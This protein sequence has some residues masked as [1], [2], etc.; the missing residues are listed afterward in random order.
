MDKHVLG[1]IGFGIAYVICCVVLI[2]IERKEP[3][4]QDE[5]LAFYTAMC[6]IMSPLC[7]AFTFVMWFYGKV[8]DIRRLRRMK[9]RE[10]ENGGMGIKPYRYGEVFGGR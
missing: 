7:L 9:K 2:L 4:W 5:N 1:L 8:D 3:E 6:I 10:R